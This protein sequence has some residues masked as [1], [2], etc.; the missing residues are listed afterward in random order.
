VDLLSGGSG[1]DLLLGGPGQGLPVEALL[2]GP[3]DDLIDGGPGPGQRSV[4]PFSAAGQRRP[5][6][7]QGTRSGPRR[8][9]QCRASRRFC[10]A[11]VVMATVQWRSVL[12]T[13]PEPARS[14]KHGC[15]APP[16][17]R[18]SASVGRSHSERRTRALRGRE[19][20]TT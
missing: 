20:V 2:G 11:D 9:R 10:P 5:T 19:A 16:S 6:T 4:S 17:A 15:E 13:T 8:P 3:G 12:A 18:A 1:H 7:V 14:A